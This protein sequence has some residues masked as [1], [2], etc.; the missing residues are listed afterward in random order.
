[1]CVVVLGDQAVI[2]TLVHIAGQVALGKLIV[3]LFVLVSVLP[4]LNGTQAVYATIGGNAKLKKGLFG[5]LFI[6]Y[7]QC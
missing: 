6:T 3:P 4:A 5:S 7:A 2:L 1:M